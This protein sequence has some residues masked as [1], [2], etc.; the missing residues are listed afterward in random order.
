VLSQLD[1]LCACKTP[2]RAPDTPDLL[3][4]FLAVAQLLAS[5]WTSI[6]GVGPLS[7][8]DQ[9]GQDV[10][11]PCV[12]RLSKSEIELLIER[13]ER[14]VDLLCCGLGRKDGVLPSTFA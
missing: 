10:A 2:S 9:C 7:D 5:T 6:E 14:V 11:E 13:I 1:L 3:P 8:V 4:L 12:M